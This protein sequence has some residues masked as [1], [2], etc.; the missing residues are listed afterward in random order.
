MVSS[1]S[2]GKKNLM[3]E[4]VQGFKI[5]VSSMG[6]APYSLIL[7]KHSPLGTVFVLQDFFSEPGH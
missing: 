6:E 5:L 7:C 2:A 3:G 1:N 4:G